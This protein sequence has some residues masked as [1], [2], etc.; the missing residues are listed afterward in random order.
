MGKETRGRNYS[1]YAARSL[2]EYIPSPALKGVKKEGER[3]VTVTKISCGVKA[4]LAVA[5]T[6]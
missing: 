4:I 1:R 3:E 6:H 5:I 2:V